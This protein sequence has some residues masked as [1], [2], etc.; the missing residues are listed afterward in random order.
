MRKTTALIAAVAVAVL[1]SLTGCASA[2]G[3]NDCVSSGAASSV[4]TATGKF[5]TAPKVT[6][7]TPLYA[8]TTQKSQLIA[9]KGAPI[10][11]GQPVAFYVTILN[12]RTG[13]VLQS[14]D[15]TST[16]FSLVTAGQSTI[17]AVTEALSCATV[18]SRIAIVGSAK[19]SH[20]GQADPSNDIDKNDSLV[21]VIDIR[22][23]YLA[24][25][26]GANQM[27]QKGLP[28]VITTANGTPGVLIPP[29]PS[30]PPKSL[31]VGVLKQGTG[32]KTKTGDYLIV[33]YT[34]VGWSDKT[35]FDSTWKDHQASVLQLGSQSIS[36]GL[37]KAL[38][39]QRVGSQVLVVVPPND[40]AIPDG[41]G[42][43]PAG[44]TVVYVVDILGIAQ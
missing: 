41:S 33:Q 13:D 25:A 38:T 27:R 9:G 42:S 40:A 4:V 10:Q 16:G 2:Q 1:T 8:H 30:T 34:G 44:E 24:K 37:T 15:Y 3:S 17:P 21:Y 23:A 18:G 14:S 43:V 39:G 29:S 32:A 28:D 36:T 11:D 5:G 35:V 7:P 6:F 19:Q 22:N 31:Q 20:N 12:G 26:N